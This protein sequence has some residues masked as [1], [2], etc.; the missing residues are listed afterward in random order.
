MISSSPAIIDALRT[1][2]ETPALASARALE[3]TLRRADS[4]PAVFGRMNQKSSVEAASD[5]DRGATERLAN[6]FDASLKV[7]R[8]IMGDVA[9]RQLTP[10]AAARRYFNATDDT[11][12]WNAADPSLQGIRIPEVEFWAETETKQRFRKHNPTDG[13]ATMAVRDNGIGLGRD[14]MAKTILALN[15]DSKLR[16]FEAIGQF[17]HGGSSALQF[18]ESCLVITQKHSANA[19]EFFWTLIVIEQEPEESKQALVRKWFAEDDS[20]PLRGFLADHPR[21]QDVLPGTIVYHFGYH[22]S[23]WIKRIVG[24]E[25]TNPWGRLGRMFFSYPLPF[26]VVGEMAR[27]DE[28]THRDI[29][30]AYYRLVSQSQKKT[31]NSPV[32]YRLPA[33]RESLVVESVAYGEFQV[34][35]FVLRDKD[36]V[37]D[38]V[39]HYH[40]VILT[41]HG[42]N[43]GEMTPTLMKDAGYP[44]LAGSTIVEIRLDGLDDEALGNIITNS[45][46][47]PKM[48]SV[49]TKALC[50][51]V[52]EI[53]AEDTGLRERE[54]A[55][56]EQKARKASR[57][58]SEEM[59]R[60]LTRIISEATGQPGRGAGRAP[61]DAPSG[62]S[63]EPP[64]LVPASDPPQIFSFLTSEPLSVPEGVR[65]S[66]RLRSDARP[67]RYTF[68][69]DSPRCFVRVDAANPLIGARIQLGCTDINDRGYGQVA[70]TVVEDPNSPIV[71]AIE[72][73]SL[74]ASLQSTDGRVLVT[75][76]PLVILPKPSPHDA[77]RQ[78]GVKPIINF[79]A[80]EDA[81][82]ATLKSLWLLDEDVEPLHAST[83]LSEAK[84]CLQLSSMEVSYH[85]AKGQHEGMDLL[86]VDVNVGNRVAMEMLRQC[87]TIERRTKAKDYYLKDILLD[88]YQHHFQIRDV[89]GTVRDALDGGSVAL[90]CG[91][92][93]LNH[94]KAVR[95]A[96][97]YSG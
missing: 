79:F 55:R 4:F 65:R 68:H 52:V 66:A 24:P 16:D 34:T 84:D 1:A 67:P 20:L 31:A 70:V 58:L 3:E 12:A 23:R 14:E 9:S 7:C 83:H 59:E 64:P 50:A 26:R 42:Q 92:C 13:L 33:T 43:H 41:L 51:R 91:E 36:K 22:R 8:S 21:L 72:V 85:S 28:G 38:Y 57:A 18:C 74:V 48:S 73:G 77:R 15:S 69:G 37:R 76:R 82:V 32:E 45:R 62:A 44:E 30:G 39:D 75:Q 56:Q 71:T 40:P 81:D 5:S 17:G 6:A 97:Q 46:E 80:P 49:F 29:V 2:I 95:L 47:M 60:F 88:C 90:L 78:P 11:A 86:N 27:G 63:G 53:L 19:E 25:Q 93:H 94:D 87:D 61:G 89:P 54:I 96:L 35:A 10:R